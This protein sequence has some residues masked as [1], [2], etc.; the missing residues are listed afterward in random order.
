MRAW[1]RRLLVAV[2]VVAVLY[3]AY[4]AFVSWS[5]GADKTI[6]V[7]AGVAQD[8][9]MFFRCVA[10][11]STRGTCDPAAPSRFTVE[12]RDRVTFRVRTDDGRPHSHDFRLLGLPYLVPPA[13]IEMEL[14]ASEESKSF[15]A[16]KSGEFRIVCELR[17]HEAAGMWGTLVV[18]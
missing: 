14:Y 8:G 3:G 6:V 9:S 7:V 13:G 17:G 2:L 10:Q 1:L 18:R 15:T 4:A 16:W 11:E 12:S 5:N